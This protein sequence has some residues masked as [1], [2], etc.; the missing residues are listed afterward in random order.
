MDLFLLCRNLDKYLSYSNEYL[1]CASMTEIK[2]AFISKD[3]L[4]T[5]EPTLID[6]SL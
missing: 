6:A 2:V 4:T 5:P 1:Y 3:K